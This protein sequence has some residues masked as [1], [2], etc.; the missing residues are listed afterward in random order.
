MC[1]VCILSANV[2]D[3]PD[4]KYRC[5][6][7]SISS[8]FGKAECRQCINNTLPADPSSTLPA[9]PSSTSL[10]A[11]PSSTLPPRGIEGS[12]GEITTKSTIDPPKGG[13]HR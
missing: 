5:D 4:D 10:P 6:G 7:C 3:D 12:N 2:T 11:A 8:E 1:E 13:M 9:D